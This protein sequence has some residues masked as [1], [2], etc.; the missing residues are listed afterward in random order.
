MTNMK[1]HLLLALMAFLPMLVSAEEVV[2]NYMKYSIHKSNKTAEVINNYGF[3]YGDIVIPTTIEVNGEAYDVTSIGNSAFQNSGITSVNIPNSVTFICGSAFSECKSLTSL[4]IPESVTLIG[5]NAFYNCTG[6]TSI[7]IPSSVRSIGYQAFYGCTGL[8]SLVMQ[9][10]ITFID[11]WAFRDCNNLSDISFP[12]SLTTIGS[13]AFDNTQWIKRQYNEGVVYAGRV[14][15][16]SNSSYCNK[17]LILNEGTKGIAASAFQNNYV[18]QSITIPKSVVSIGNNAF[19][20]S[21]LKSIIVEEGNPVFDSRENC[22]AIIETATNTLIYGCINTIIPTSIKTIGRNAFTENAPNSITIPEGVTHIESD[23]FSNCSL[24]KITFPES[25]IY[26]GQGAFYNT[27]W[28][29][30][31][32]DGLVYAGPILY[33]YKGE[34]PENTSITIKEGTKSICGS[35][36]CN[37]KNLVSI[38]IPEGLES[39]GNS[40]FLNCTNLNNINFP[41]SLKYI[42]SGALSNTAWYK[43]QPD[44]VVYAGP[45]V[46]YYK[47]NMLANSEIVINSGTT[48]IAVYALSSNSNTSMKN[49][50]SV[51]LPVSIKNICL[52]AFWGSG[53]T[54]LVLPQG[55]KEIGQ[56]AFS[57]CTSLTSVSIPASVESIGLWAFLGCKSLNDV[58][59]YATTVPKVNNNIFNYVH[60]THATLHVPATSVEAYRTISPWNSFKNIVPIEGEVPSVEKCATPIITFANGKLH[61]A[62]ETEGV[63]FVPMVTSTPNQLQNGNEL[64]IGGT[65]TVSVYAVKEGYDNSDTATMTFN[66]SQMGD[67]NADGEL[68][69]ADVTALVNKILG[70]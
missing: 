67:M 58:Y 9:E 13:H 57:N 18:I 43:S 39:I 19:I 50:F 32:P 48:A 1:K 11:E 8:T 42:D 6:L 3:Y 63:E 70:K 34:M 59:C 56:E 10:G 60:M 27:P 33:H 36:F 37:Y 5:D 31:Q 14:A 4:N 21:G 46:Y 25:L 24:S 62:C 44:G 49:A 47:G 40:A 20:S 66:I 61:F 15:Y 68:N 54:S 52:R 69:A 45:V 26:I 16:S 17:D 55:T 29:N 38:S 23:A 41:A 65:Y 64:E 51:S 53:I 35:A 12:N 28:N 7:S 22:N 2:I 30:N